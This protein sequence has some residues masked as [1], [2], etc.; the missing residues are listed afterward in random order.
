MNRDKIDTATTAQPVTLPNLDTKLWSQIFPAMD[1]DGLQLGGPERP[2]EFLLHLAVNR[3]CAVDL[4]AEGRILSLRWRADEHGSAGEEFQ[5]A[6]GGIPVPFLV[7]HRNAR[8]ILV[9]DH[10]A[11]LVGANGIAIKQVD[12]KIEFIKAED[13]LGLAF[14]PTVSPL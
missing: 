14:R 12:G 3:R 8:G 11:L 4:D 1:E 10:T 5:N 6:I 9:S 7:L 13:I 2:T